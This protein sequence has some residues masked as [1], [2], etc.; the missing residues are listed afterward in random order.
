MRTPAV[1]ELGKEHNRA[2]YGYL[3]IHWL[4]EAH[5]FP[6]LADPLVLPPLRSHPPVAA[7]RDWARRQ[8]YEC[9]FAADVGG[10][11]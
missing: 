11:P 10:R 4:W 8:G 9:G 7:S 3:V 5:H 6:L 1:P 2:G